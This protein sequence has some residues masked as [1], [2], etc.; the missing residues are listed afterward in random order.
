MTKYQKQMKKVLALG[1][2]AAAMISC[3]APTGDLVGASSGIAYRPADPFG[4]VQ[5]PGGT[6]TMGSNDQNVPYAH[7]TPMR[8]VTMH[9]FWM[10]QMEITNDEYRQYVN[11]VRDSIARVTLADA[12]VEGY[13][14][15]EENEEGDFL[16][17]PYINWDVEIDWS[18]DDELFVDALEPMYIPE[19]ERV[20]GKKSFDTRNWTYSYSY[21]DNKAAGKKKNRFDP[22]T[23]T[24]REGYSRKSLENTKTVKVYPD[25]LV[26]L[27]DFAYAYTY[28]EPIFSNYFWHPS[29]GQYP[30]VGVNWDQA[31]GFCAWRTEYRNKALYE[32]EVGYETSFRLPTEM[33]WEY[34]ARGGKQLSV[35]PWGGLYPTNSKGC[36]LANFKPRRGEYGADGYVFTARADAYWSNGYGLFNMSGNVAEWTSTP[37]EQTQYSYY[38][39]L[40]PDFRYDALDSDHP[41]LKRK[42]TKGGSWKDI[43]AF[44]QIASRDYEYLD[45]A[46][47]YIGFRCVKTYARVDD[48]EF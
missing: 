7:T 45:T 39:D 36:F 15:I 44:I 14:M 4:M 43:G 3:G 33:E 40:N 35:Y 24:Y 46:K 34:A 6:Y 26:W 9:S 25:T 22:S 47:S 37:F 12:G 2:I 48:I 31:N 8:T 1:V 21:I 27:H 38:H 11:W 32:G 41:M 30:V 20:F 29:Y 16:E 5:V 19:E 10:D 17:K 18:S 42:I 23:G 13:E 28:N